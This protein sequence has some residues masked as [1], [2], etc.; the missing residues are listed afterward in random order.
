MTYY[1]RKGE[2]LQDAYGNE[3]IK[4]GL[5]HTWYCVIKSE[6]AEYED[7]Y[8]Y[9]NERFDRNDGWVNSFST[10]IIL[11]PIDFDSLI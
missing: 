5:Y 7:I 1:V 4:D 9:H 8:I 6:D 2:K 10:H 3:T 11:K